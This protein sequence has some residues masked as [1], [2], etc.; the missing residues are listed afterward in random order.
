MTSFTLGVASRVAK[1]EFDD[2]PPDVVELVRQCTLDWF[3]V[4]LAGS[5]EPAAQIVLAEA[6]EE[7]PST[8]DGG[9]TVV[10]RAERLPASMAALVNGT[11]SHALDYDDVNSAMN[12]H[13]T[14]PILGALLAL[15][16][17]RSVS[18]RDLVCAFVAGYE[19]ENRVGRALGSAPYQ[20]GFHATGTV[21]TLGAAAACA[22]LLHL[23]PDTTA[24]ALGIAATQAAG[25]KSM[26][27]TMS[28]PLHAGKACANGL[29]AARLAAR[30][31]TAHPASIETEQGFA[32]V[33]G[34][35]RDL[36]QPR[37]EPEWFLRNN[38]F[39]YHAACFAT[40]STIE[41]V[42]RLRAR[43]GF[44]RADVDRVVVHANAAQMRMCAIPEPATGLEAKFSFRHLV[45][46]TLSDVDTSN[47][48]SFTDASARDE[49]LVALRQRVHV[50]PDGPPQAGTP[51]EVVLLD[52][53]TLS[54]AHD[55]NIPASDLAEQRAALR[56]KFDA[57]G[58]PVLGSAATQRLAGLVAEL[59]RLDDVAD[60]MSASRSG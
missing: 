29:L 26:F 28:K 40:H 13:P 50:E 21:G 54:I 19:A 56:A 35:R 27:G 43:A 18:G 6:L 53:R 5:F 2:I 51:V 11:A 4:T 55:V 31:F 25:M 59:D 45:A 30:G 23:D 3:G 22:R 12:G 15:G 20:R 58:S 37:A 41:G 17:T 7:C 52:G 49:G 38:L 16:E 57:L 10:G 48:E 34:G 24:V 14:V 39:K 33:T 60:L 32:E 36:D 8:A 9:A 42:R 44:A 1:L 46:M 47:T